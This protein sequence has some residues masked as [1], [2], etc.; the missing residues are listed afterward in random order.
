MLELSNAEALV[1]FEWLAAHDGTVAVNDPAEQT[2][3]WR[4]EAQLEKALVEPLSPDY[5]DALRRAR[6]RVQGQEE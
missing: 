3:L 4:L 2:V 5:K 6:S 1:L